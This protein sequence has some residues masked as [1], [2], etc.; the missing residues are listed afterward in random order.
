[1]KKKKNMFSFM[2]D[3][4]KLVKLIRENNYISWTITIGGIIAIL[5]MGIVWIKA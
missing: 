2:K 1:M 4:N 3:D 5:Y